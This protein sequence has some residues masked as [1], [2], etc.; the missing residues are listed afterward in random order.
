MMASMPIFRVRRSGNSL[1]LVIPSELARDMKLRVGDNVL[2][3]M[4]KIPDIIE[5]AGKLRGIMTAD[6]FTRLSNEG[7][8]LG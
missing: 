1:V 7:E 6:E 8:D 3:T 2:A 4:E 5:F